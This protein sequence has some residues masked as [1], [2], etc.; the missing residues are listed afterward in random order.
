MED[1]VITVKRRFRRPFQYPLSLLFLL[2]TT[3]AVLVVL[4]KVLLPPEPR[5]YPRIRASV[6]ENEIYDPA[7]G[8]IVRHRRESFSVAFT[9][10]TVSESYVD[11]Q[12]DGLVD[13]VCIE[14]TGIVNW[15]RRAKPFNYSR[16]FP[17]IDNFNGPIPPLLQ[18]RFQ[19]IRLQVEQQVDLKKLRKHQSRYPV[20]PVDFPTFE[21]FVAD[22]DRQNPEKTWK[23]TLAEA[24]TWGV[25][26]SPNG[27]ARSEDGQLEKTN[28]TV[29]ITE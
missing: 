13:V 7:F 5:R 19:Q 12:S 3:I 10:Q 18:A 2:V 15:Q 28:E 20:L 24:R 8:R 6:G 25:R 14:S 4:L 1:F 29:D 23:Q 11:L 16:G 21:E 22:Y 26:F 17:V 27:A 9:K